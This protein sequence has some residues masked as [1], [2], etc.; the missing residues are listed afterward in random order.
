MSTKDNSPTQDLV[1]RYRASDDDGREKIFA[2]L[3]KSYHNESN[4]SPS[5]PSAAIEQLLLALMSQEISTSEEPFDLETAFQEL[6]SGMQI[7]C[8]ASPSHLDQAWNSTINLINSLKENELAQKHNAHHLAVDGLEVWIAENASGDSCS[9]NDN[10][11]PTRPLDPSILSVPDALWKQDAT[12][13]LSKL[14]A[15]R[16]RRRNNIVNKVIQARALRDGYAA[17]SPTT[18]RGALELRFIEVALMRGKGEVLFNG[19]Y[20]SSA[21]VIAATFLLRG[22]ARSLLDSL[23]GE[24]FQFGDSMHLP[25]LK[26][27]EKGSEE[28]LQGWKEALEGFVVGGGGERGNDDFA[29]MSYAALALENLS[30]PRDETSSELFSWDNLTL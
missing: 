2:D 27:G 25:A 19:H 28:R 3:F 4:T 14:A 15:N 16:A 24:G 6:Y 13:Q 7:F 12:K 17:T 8:H 18:F 21:D 10:E 22:C 29:L 20:Q 1:E 5:D 26:A 9:Q 11:N 23:P 30:R